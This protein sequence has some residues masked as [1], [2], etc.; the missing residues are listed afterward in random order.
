MN[1]STNINITIAT[2]NGSGSQSANEILLRSL[3]NQGYSVGGK[4]LF[5]S[6]IAGLATWFNLRINQHA[7]TSFQKTPDVLV[8]M[9]QQTFYKDLK[10]LRKD[11]FVIYNS[12]FK[13]LAKKELEEFKTLALPCREMLKP[14]ES[15][16]KLRKF[17]TNMLYVGALTRLLDL[18]LEIIKSVVKSKFKSKA[19]VLN[20]NLQ[21]IEAGYHYKIDLDSNLSL[22]KWPVK[23]PEK[24]IVAHGNQASALGLVYGG[25]TFMSWYPITPSSSLA[26]DFERYAHQLR[27]DKD[28]KNKFT[29]VQAEDELGAISMVIGAGWTG[30][31]AATTTSGPGLSLMSEAAGLSYFAEVPAVIWNVQ[32]AG[33]STGLPTRTMQGDLLSAANLSHGDTEHIVLLPA[34]LQECFEFGQICFDLAESF[35]TLVIVLSDLDLGMNFWISDDLKFI[36]KPY[37]RGK[38]LSAEDL[39][40][41]PFHRYEDLDKDGICYRT[42]PGTKHEKA[43]YFT[44][45]TSHDKDA[46]YSESPDDFEEQLNRIKFKITN[47]RSSLPAPY[48]DKKDSH[49]IAIICYGSTDSA[50]KEVRDSLSLKDIHSNYLRIKSLPLNDEIKNFIE[51]HQRVYVVEQNRD[52]QMNSIII[53]DFPELSRKLISITQFNGLPIEAEK[54]K[55]KIIKAEEIARN[56][57]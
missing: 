34:S 27:K 53:K 32:R 44:R 49:K 6:N 47:S 57:N 28:Q 20:Y 45:G 23:K 31:R 52:G 13:L 22:K 26:E 37:N 5:P 51:A 18:D 1:S 7:Y 4:N 2:V 43:A 21:A 8:A 48:I 54:I 19:E 40:E 39:N 41:K 9:N 55:Q 16:I 36:D 25:C 29:V 14:I 42:L 30:C 33:P 12:D 24:K 46:Q 50:I 10:N 3:F 38:V 35:Q 15:P 56:K 11:G 17:L